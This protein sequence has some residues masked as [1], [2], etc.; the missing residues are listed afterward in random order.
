MAIG[1]G[2]SKEEQPDS[3]AGLAG[4][5]STNLL[6]LMEGILER[7][8]GLT[9]KEWENVRGAVASLHHVYWDSLRTH[10]GILPRLEP[11]LYG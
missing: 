2:C 8:D 6:R 10:Q 1:K 5:P 3:G 9:C 11:R 7:L 4:T